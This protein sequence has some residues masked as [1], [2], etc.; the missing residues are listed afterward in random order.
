MTTPLRQLLDKYRSLAPTER[1]KGTYLEKLSV[2]FL[3][4]DAT[5]QA[6]FEDAWLYSDWA[7][8]Q[9]VGG[10]DIGIDVV[11]KIHDSNR[12][13]AV[14]CKFYADG[15]VIQKA[16]TDS[17]FANANQDCFERTMFIDT[18]NKKW[19]SNAL[20][21][22]EKQEKPCTIIGISQLEASNI[23]WSKFH[24]ED[25]VEVFAKKE[26]RQHQIDALA[27]VK[28][29]LIEDGLDRG[30]VIMAC[31]TG[32]TYTALQFAQD[33]DLAGVGKRVLFL[34]PSLALMSQT[35]REWHNDAL[36]PLRSFAVCSDSEVGKR[37]N[38]A[39]DI[40]ESTRLD[41]E[42][43]ATTDYVKI[44]REAKA[45]AADRLTVIFSTYQS[46]ETIS[47]AQ[48]IDG[49]EE[50]DLIIC[51]EAHRTTGA[52]LD[53]EDE[54]DFVKVHDD[55]FIK[56]K[57]RIYMTATPRVYSSEVKSTA[58]EVNATVYSMDDEDKF[59]R[60]LFV[61]GFGWAVENKLLTDYKV[62]V[63]A[64]DEGVVSASI[65]NRFKESEHELKLD[66]ATKIIGCYKALTKSGIKDELGNDP[67]PMTRALAFCK[68][69][70][71]SKMVAGEF[72]NVV[73]EYLES[74]LGSDSLAGVARLDCQL[75]HVDGTMGAKERGKY[76][77]WLKEDTEDKCRILTNAKCLSEGVDVP[78]LDAIMFMHPR[79]SQVDVVQSVGRVMRRAPGKQMGYVIIP[80]GI[81][82][83]V[84]PDKALDDNARYKVV[85][86]I[87]N[88]LRSHDERLEAKLNQG[89]LGEDISSH[90]EVIAISK[91]LPIKAEPKKK[92][93]D[94]GGGS[95]K[96]D[97]DEATSK[98]KEKKIE[99]LSLPM[100]EITK[101][102]LAKIVKKC[103]NRTYWSDWSTKLAKIADAYI[104]RITALV[105]KDNSP[106]QKTFNEF[107][108]EIRDDLNETI[109]RDDAIEM[110]AQHMITKPVFDALF[111]GYDFAHRNPVSRAMESVLEVLFA[112]N[113][114]TESSE[115]NGFYESV[116][117][118]VAGVKDG[119]VKQDII[120]ELYDNFFK[121][122]FKRLQQKLGIVYTPVEVVDFIIHSVNDALQNEFGQ[123]LGSKG[124]H[125]LDPFTGT[126]TFIT[127]LLQSGLIKPEELEHKF[128]NEIHAN[129]IVLLA[130]YIAAI[131]IEAAYHSLQGGDYTPFEGICLTDTFQLYEQEKDMISELMTDNSS[132]RTRQ[133]ELDIRVIMGNPPYSAGQK[134]ANDDAANIAYPNLDLRISDTYSKKSKAVLQKGIYNS[135]VRAFRWASDKIGDSG[136]VAFV[137]GAGWID[138]NS[139]D[140]M[141]ASLQSEFSNLYIVHLRGDIRKNMLTKGKA[142]EGENV[143]EQGSMSG[144]SIA[145]LVK[146]P[147]SAQLG[148]IN[149][150]D[151]GKDKKRSEKLEI[152]TKLHG[153]TKISDN[154]SWT[155][156]VPN[157]FND[158]L[159]QR[160]TSFDSYVSIGD[161]KD[162]NSTVLFENFTLGIS[163]N[164]DHWVYNFSKSKLVENVRRTIDFYNGE[165]AKN[166]DMTP[167]SFESSFNADSTK[168]S[169]TRSLKADFVSKKKLNFEE[170]FLITSSYRPFQTQN[171]YFSRRLNEMVLQIPKLFPQTDAENLV[172][173]LNG[174][175]DS[176]GFST[177][178]TKYLP[179][180]HFM[181]S[182]QNFPLYIYESLEGSNLFAGSSEFHRREAVTDDGLKHF[183]DAYAGEEIVKEDIFYYVYGL[184]HSEDYR[185][186]FADNLSKQLPRIP[187]VKTASGFWA[188]VN[189]GRALG[190]MHVN[191]ET[192]APYPI[193]IKQGNLDLAVIDDPVQYF[194]VKQMK[195]GGK[196]GDRDK[197]QIIYNDDITIQNIPLEAYDYVVNGKPAIDWVV[198]R[199]RVKPDKDSGIVNDANDYANETMNNPRYPL[200]LLARVIN[201]SLETMKIV[202]S[203]PKLE[204]E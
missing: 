39:E 58:K 192:Y 46:I 199:Q 71:S 52:K 164:R 65:Q 67:H 87:L 15:A 140:G 37:Q 148:K 96:A 85:W 117:R 126:G 88:A 180:L 81:P 32:K 106:E 184:L 41:L 175:G 10:K 122:G 125:I 157:Q 204:I 89:A 152:V 121:I 42:I 142:G 68:D 34:V 150:Y 163:T 100:D 83:G 168:I 104:T 198:E 43:P 92:S 3:R 103:G 74:E 111:E 147:K 196:V 94:L 11:A 91:Q 13:C 113:L 195:Y 75:N 154:G 44:A 162:R 166:S 130:Y 2:V 123:T 161:K 28:K 145:I 144:I 143:F 48:N 136:V 171:L 158:W 114:E 124:V 134:S 115:L 129:E 189:A 112:N 108:A 21:Q 29:G 105:Q 137:T 120:R 179:N 159:N 155:D 36:V 167:T 173:S 128:K 76:L 14:Q 66:D 151:I 181:R 33:Q 70:A 56:G 176:A 119:K 35:I 132:R 131:N 201:I 200:E 16:D 98:P 12:F 61:R 55:Y 118:N 80:I 102:I 202:R 63:L 170:G 107:L 193:E 185:N 139:M 156:I 84:E 149:F 82:A 62:L 77:D 54:S 45:E 182:S 7:K 31:G 133:K 169:W 174:I 59:G 18:T 51:D 49:L 19:S 138:G 40:A 95:A 101:A 60:D 110:L 141:R 197:T 1:D 153:I 27:A 190:E 26:P 47:K 8:L 25:T 146:N 57:K 9:G 172:I 187:C 20:E 183:Q 4:T 30:K 109:S 78:A 90:I 188:F 135:Y 22:A 72:A 6:Q 50:F 64:I 186:R 203:L 79:K 165:L 160:D 97:D 191:F 177:L 38:S 69:I 116:R 86:Q 17:F 99:Q 127:R 93:M 73:N 53:D 23:D 24:W 194:R 5:M 178:M